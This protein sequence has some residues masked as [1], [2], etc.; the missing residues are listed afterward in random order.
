MAAVLPKSAHV[1]AEAQQRV[2]ALTGSGLQAKYLDTHFYP[3]LLLAGTTPPATPTEESF[4]VYLGPFQTQV[5]AEN[6]CTAISNATGEAC[7]AAQPD[8]P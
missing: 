6:Q 8:P 1:E 5:D 3:R 7:V 2:Q 4:L